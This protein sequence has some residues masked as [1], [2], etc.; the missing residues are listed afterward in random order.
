MTL[1]CVGFAKE[2]VRSPAVIVTLLGFGLSSV[3]SVPILVVQVTLVS[4]V[5]S[6]VVGVAVRSIKPSSVTCDCGDTVTRSESSKARK[7]TINMLSAA[8][9]CTVLTLSLQYQ[10]HSFL[11]KKYLTWKTVHMD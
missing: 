3:T 10:K 6:P 1:I 7:S 9:Y 5:E 2:V 4:V 11:E 8:M